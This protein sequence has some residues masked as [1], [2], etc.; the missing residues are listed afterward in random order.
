MAYI[1]TSEQ[2]DRLQEIEESLRILPANAFEKALEECDS[3][4]SVGNKALGILIGNLT[5]VTKKLEILCEE[6]NISL[7]NE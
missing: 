2:K 7:E 4:F 5:D 3:P 6:L 1:M